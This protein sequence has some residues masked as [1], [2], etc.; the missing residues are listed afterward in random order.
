MSFD[1]RVSMILNFQDTI[2][3]PTQ[4]S[5]PYPLS[6]AL[7]LSIPPACAGKGAKTPSPSPLVAAKAALVVF[8]K[9]SRRESPSEDWEA[10]KEI[11][12]VR[13]FCISTTLNADADW[14]SMASAAS[15]EVFMI[16]L[17]VN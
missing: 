7:A 2:L 6:L 3:M 10:A 9:K 12:F 4:L 5:L 14:Q 11:S 1:E 8:A 16:F 15:V 17:M 13:L